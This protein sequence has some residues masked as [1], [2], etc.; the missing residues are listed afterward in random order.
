MFTNPCGG[1]V[2]KIVN[3]CT[4]LSIN[5][6]ER[7]KRKQ[8]STLNVSRILTGDQK[9]PEINKWKDFQN[10]NENRIYKLNFLFEQ[11]TCVSSQCFLFEYINGICTIKEVIHLSC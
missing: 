2:I 3:C 7:A 11:W 5:D 9:M 6:I 4:V 1:L 8:E 10:V